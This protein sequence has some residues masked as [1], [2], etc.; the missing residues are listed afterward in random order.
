MERAVGCAVGIFIGEMI[1]ASQLL[2]LNVINGVQKSVPEI[3][4]TPIFIPEGRITGFDD[5]Y[6]N[7]VDCWA[8]VNHS[9]HSEDRLRHSEDRLSN[10]FAAF[11]RMGYTAGLEK[12][13]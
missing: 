7:S 12:Y 2:D 9:F 8:S 13:S 3:K 5:C 4:K 11:E 6:A 1:S 10:V